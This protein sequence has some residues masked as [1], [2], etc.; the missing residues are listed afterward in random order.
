MNKIALERVGEMRN[1][2]YVAVLALVSCSGGG[3]YDL[4]PPEAL[5]LRENFGGIAVADFN[6]DGLNDIAVGTTLTEDRRFVDTRISIYVQRPTSPGSFLAPRQFDSNPNGSLA[7]MLVADDFQQNGLPDLIATRWNEGGFRLLLNDPAQP[8][9]LTPSVHYETGPADST[10][11]RSQAVG[12]IDAD[13]F[14]DVVI[15]TE[16]LV[17]WVPQNAG[18]LGTF[19]PPRPIGEGRDDVQIGDVNGDGLLDVVVLGVNGSVSQSILI[20]Y[21]NTSAPGQFLSPRRLTTTD[22]AKHI[23]IADY[24][25]NGRIDIAVAVT[26]IDSDDFD[27]HAAMVVFRQIAPDS[28]SQSAVTRTGGL[29]DFE[30]FE[31]FETVNLDGDIFPEVVFW[32]SSDVHDP[33]VRIMETNAAGA[34]TILMD[35]VIPNEPNNF[36][37][38]IGRLSIG[39]LNNDTLDDI[40]LIHKGLYVFFRQPGGT[41]AFDTA[42]KLNTPP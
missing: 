4:V 29:G 9:T 10:F 12:D 27:S 24:D 16:E 3:Y 11:G 18:N 37:S 1:F 2:L 15:V 7:R 34:P 39:D 38:S 5:E 21:N 36:S 41:L 32:F 23:G 42:V 8:G 19:D 33:V 20:Y 6:A 22:F 28:F 35:L 25:G 17:Q 40:A 31:V 26:Q 14:P 13:G 30:F